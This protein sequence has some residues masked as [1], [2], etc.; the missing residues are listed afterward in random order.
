LTGFIKNGDGDIMA[1]A[2]LPDISDEEE[3]L[4]SHYNHWDDVILI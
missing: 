3:K 1:A 2:G 4:V